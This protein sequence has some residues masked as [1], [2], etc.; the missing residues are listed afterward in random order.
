[1]SRDEVVVGMTEVALAAYRSNAWITDEAKML[2]AIRAALEWMDD[3]AD[4]SAMKRYVEG[5]W[6]RQELSAMRC[7]LALAD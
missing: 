5:E 2:A 3:S 4:L 7:D 1:M 6:S